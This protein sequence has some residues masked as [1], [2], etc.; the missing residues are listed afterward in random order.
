MFRYIRIAVLLYILLFVALGS[1]VTRSISTDW[2]RPLWVN[3]YPVNGDGS[4]E[5]ARYIAKLTRRQFDPVIGFFEREARR[6]GHAVDQPVGIHLGPEI[7][8]RPP[9]PPASGNVL[10]RVWWSLKLRYWTW[11]A[12]R[13]DGLP[14]PD[15]RIFMV[16][17]EATDGRVLE[18]SLGLSKGMVGIVN[19]F[20][21]RH[22][23]GANQMVL[24]HELLH[25]LGATD[26]YSFDTGLPLFPHG[27]AEP[28]LKPLLPQSKTEIMGGRRPVDEHWAEIPSSLKRVIIGPVT[29][30]EVG[31]LE[32]G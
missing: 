7:G 18:A 4:A 14:T 21:S 10:A 29:A 17:F 19:A 25:T 2:Q 22:Q 3:V 9:A 8:E 13:D 5:T 26:K 28:D 27:Y 6:Y 12:T 11:A 1:W 24:A 30:V 15:V 16:Y 31:L 32:P 20:A 23:R